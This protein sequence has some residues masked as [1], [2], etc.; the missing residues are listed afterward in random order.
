[1][2]TVT[3]MALFA[4]HVGLGALAVVSWY[5]ALETSFEVAVLYGVGVAVGSVV[6][7]PELGAVFLDLNSWSEIAGAVRFVVAG[8]GVGVVLGVLVFEPEVSGERVSG[9]DVDEQGQRVIQ[10]SG[11]GAT[12]V[13][14]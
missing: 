1:M 13:E 10:E 12:E 4:V 9:Y 11:S 7:W 5:K 14:N 6:L 2:L 3:H 8:A